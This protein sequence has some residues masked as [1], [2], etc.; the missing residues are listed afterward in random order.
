MGNLRKLLWTWQNFRQLILLRTERLNTYGKMEQ[1]RVLDHLLKHCSDSDMFSP[2][3][4]DRKWYLDRIR[5]ESCKMDHFDRTS[6]PRFSQTPKP[7]NENCYTTP[8]VT[9]VILSFIGRTETLMFYLIFS[10]D[11]K[12]VLTRNFLFNSLSKAYIFTI[13]IF[14]GFCL[15]FDMPTNRT[16]NTKKDENGYVST[17]VAKYE[18]TIAATNDSSSK[19]LLERLRYGS[20][21]GRTRCQTTQP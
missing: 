17:L 2:N 5:G 15:G 1:P 18:E 4:E 10:D 3:S 11:S 7:F 6:I 20:I 21:T 9:L 19:P 16:N 12:T 8:E 14:I 13:F